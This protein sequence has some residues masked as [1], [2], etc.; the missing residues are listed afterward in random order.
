MGY[1]SCISR[2][3]QTRVAR[4][5]CGLLTTLSGPQPRPARA[6][7]AH[8]NAQ[9]FSVFPLETT[10][11]GARALTALTVWLEGAVFSLPLVGGGGTSFS[12]PPF[13]IAGGVLYP[14]SRTGPAK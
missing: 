6:A 10:R 4:G 13:G 12:S 11:S 5:V 3:G 7:G 2:S 9:R 8:R 14:V 1:P